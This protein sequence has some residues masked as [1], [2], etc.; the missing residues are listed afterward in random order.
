[1]KILHVAA[2]LDPKRGGPTKVVEELTQALAGKR[3]DVSIFAPSE[4]A[5]TTYISNRNGVTVKTFPT[6]VLSKLWPFHSPAFTKTLQKELIDF[7]LIHI[8][9]IW[10]HPV[11]ASY[12]ISKSIRKPYLIT[13]HGSLEPSC[14]NYK[15]FKKKIYT[16]LIERRIL[17]EADALHAVTEDEIQSIQNFVD[18]ENIYCIPNGLNMQTFENLP[19]KDII[20]NLY[21]QIKGKKVILFLGRIH[22][23]KGLDTLAEAFGMIVRKN[24]NA[25]LLIVGPNSDNYRHQIEK[26]LSREDLSNKAIFTGTL[27]GN[28]KLAALNRADIF[29]LPSHSEGFSISILEAMGCGLPVIITNQCHFPEVEQMQAGKI[30]D[31]DAAQLAEIIMELLDNPKLCRQM[32]QAGKELVRDRYTWGKAADKMIELYE[33]ILNKQKLTDL[34][35]R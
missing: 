15:A 8:H 13:I 14:L 7:D 25:C 32:G 3:V 9:E 26:I 1:M 16:A 18:N 12:K 27:M 23:K 17:R 28:L 20:E 29:V 2:S 19:E 5:K 24:K 33:K 4:D 31:G 30:T 10:H 34:Q 21:P 11:F 35:N 22:P 6:S